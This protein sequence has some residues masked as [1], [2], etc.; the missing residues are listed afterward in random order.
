MNELC[1]GKRGL[2]LYQM[3]NF[4]PFQTERVCRRQFQIDENG[5]KFSKWVDKTVVKGDIAR[6]G[7]NYRQFKYSYIDDFGL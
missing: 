3:T 4:G 6:N 2:T 1:S 7:S 5:A